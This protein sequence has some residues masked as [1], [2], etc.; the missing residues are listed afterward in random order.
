MRETL[1]ITLRK[2][3]VKMSQDQKVPI[4]DEPEED[5]GGDLELHLEDILGYFEETSKSGTADTAPHPSA[6]LKEET[7]VVLK[8][9]RDDLKEVLDFI[10]E[11]DH[12]LV[13]VPI[14]QIDK[15]V[16]FLVGRRETW[17]DLA[18]RLHEIGGGLLEWSKDTNLKIQESLHDKATTKP[19]SD[20]VPTVIR[21]LPRGLQGRDPGTKR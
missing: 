7:H 11:I 20:T 16:H 14:R 18:D 17:Q 3:H 8:Q 21:N 2:V 4:T 12:G 13:H 15:V 9:V 1:N 5:H 10:E 19:V 6:V